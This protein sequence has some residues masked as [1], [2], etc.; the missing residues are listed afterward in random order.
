[1]QIKILNYKPHSTGL[2]QGFVDILYLPKKP[3]EVYGLKLFNK[4]GRRWIN[5]PSK[6]VVDPSGEKKYF[7]HMRYLERA[8]MDE[9]SEEVKEAIDAYLKENVQPDTKEE[10]PF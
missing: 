7:P 3:I 8:D 10:F 4:N 2:L 6:E 5:F 9:F 1:M